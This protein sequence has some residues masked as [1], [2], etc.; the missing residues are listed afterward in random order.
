VQL[1]KVAEANRTTTNNA[2]LAST[3]NLPA[4]R[5]VCQITITHPTHTLF[6]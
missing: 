4:T 1:I 2:H 3:R 6:S 5:H